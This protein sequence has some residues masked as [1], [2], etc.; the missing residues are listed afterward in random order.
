VNDAMFGRHD[1]DFL[2]KTSGIA[3]LPRV[4]VTG[5]V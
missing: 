3:W 1:F 2:L 4:K 5:K